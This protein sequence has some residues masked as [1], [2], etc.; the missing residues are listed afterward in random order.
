MSPTH[1]W[2]GALAVQSLSNRLGATGSVCREF[3]VALNLRASLT[4]SLWPCRLA[5]TVLRF[6]DRPSSMRS[7]TN[8]RAPKRAPS[9]VRHSLVDNGLLTAPQRGFATTF[10]PAIVATAHDAKRPAHKVKVKHLAMVVGEGVLHFRFF[11][12]YTAV[13]L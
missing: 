13:F 5:E 4:R 11:A 7:C 3:V 2:K 8:L 12:K 10:A 9:A 6:T 1:F